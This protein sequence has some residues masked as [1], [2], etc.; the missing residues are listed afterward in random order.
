MLQR[1]LL[2]IKKPTT[3][4]VIINT[5]GN[6]LNVFFTALFVL[7]LVRIFS[8]SQYGVLSV[9][10]GI[11]YVLANILDFGTTATIYSYLP[12]MIERKAT[13]IYRFV[14]TTF[15]YQSLF[16]GIVIFVLLLTFPYLDKVFFKTGAPLS[17]LYMTSFMVLF[18]I[19][20]NFVL[21]ILFASKKFIHANLYL[22]LSNVIKTAVILLLA[23]AHQVTVGSIS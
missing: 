23:S 20:Q 2:F 8:R 13:N 19:W 12:P 1:F 11:A 6:Y 9:L 22:N 7:L 10:L 21:N 5:F 16:S 15:I 4:N 3:R 17:D 14:K 18:L